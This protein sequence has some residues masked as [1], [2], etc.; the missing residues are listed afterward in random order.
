M[1][2]VSTLHTIPAASWHK[3][4][5]GRFKQQYLFFDQPKAETKYL[6]H[7]ISAIQCQ[8]SKYE[9]VFFCYFFLFKIAYQTL[10][11]ANGKLSQSE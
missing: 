6:F 10:D 7:I 5:Q 8:K 9:D 11:A 3:T 2:T 1:P 4:I